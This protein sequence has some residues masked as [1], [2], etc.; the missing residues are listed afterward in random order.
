MKTIRGKITVFFALCLVFVG[1][2]TGLYYENTM[3]LRKK[4][5]I[6]ENFDDLLNNILELRRYEK[7][8]TY[9]HDTAS[10]D[11]SV[12]Y[13][14]KMEDAF[15]RYRKEITQ[16][17]GSEECNTFQRDMT[18]YKHHL[19]QNMSL[20]KM[21]TPTM[22]LKGIREKGKALVDFAHRLIKVKRKRINR[23]LNR[24][25]IIPLGSLAAFV[26][27]I[28]VVFQL[29][30]RGILKCL[31][32]VEQ[33]TKEVAKEKFTPILSYTDRK[34]EISR[35]IVAFNKM[36]QELESRQEQLLQS[37]KMASIGTF[38]S[39][40]A[41]E[42]NNPINNISLV[43]ES[44]MED[45]EIMSHDERMRLYQDLMNQADRSSEIVRNLLEFSR[46]RHPRLEEVSLERLVDKTA[47]L[48]KNELR[49]NHITFS[50]EIQ[51]QIPSLKSDKSGLQQVL[52]N[53]YLNSIQA[54]DGGGDLKVVLE[55]EP[56]GKE[57]RLDV[58]DTGKGIP[59]EHLD[60]IFDPFFSTKKEGEGTGLGLSVSYNIIK[61]LGGRI[62]VKTQPGYGT[63]FSIFLPVGEKK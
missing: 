49:L 33:A 11:E 9:Y 16:V 63:C 8:F 57:I 14:F 3:S 61:K 7:N 47:R 24:S 46:A 38:T 23:T 15:K 39:G 25:L 17:L 6:I 30:N 53:L 56:N 31:S 45:D 37:R 35:L 5:V 27:L 42:L 40:I 44:L 4:L 41:H 55:L 32:V 12:F 54:M 34:D 58:K 1:A 22:D 43:V 13:F 62:E 19:E 29:V 48:V 10:L 28:I 20:V 59:P 21:G 52:L 18:A 51:S 26:L 60:S 36:A 50:K 2:L